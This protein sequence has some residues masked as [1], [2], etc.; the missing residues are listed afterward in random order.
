MTE[1]PEAAPEQEDICLKL[2]DGVFDMAIDGKVNSI[3]MVIVTEPGKYRIVA[4]GPD[5]D[6]MAAGAEAMLVGQFK[7]LLGK[8]WKSNIKSFSVAPIP[9]SSKEQ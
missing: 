6:G 8:A 1:A 7:S 5:V 4:A 9:L 2:I 3:A